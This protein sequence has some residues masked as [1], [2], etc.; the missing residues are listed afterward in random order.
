MSSDSSIPP[1]TLMVVVGSKNPV[2]ISAARN[3]VAILYP[4]HQVICEGMDAPSGVSDQ[5]MSAAETRT[6]AINRTLYCRTTYI[7]SHDKPA[8]FYM[9]M[10]GG[11]DCFDDEGPSTFAYVVVADQQRQ[12]VGRSAYMPLPQSIYAE[13]QAGAELGPLIDQRFNTRNI[14]QKGGAIG[15]LTQGK[16]TRESI[17]TQALILALVPFIH[18]N[19]YHQ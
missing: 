19:L 2:K 6:G 7:A 18:P 12:S 16:A 9:A 3:A 5:P 10:E 14:K 17:Y 15:L 8:D 1:K 13:L 4:D 11:V